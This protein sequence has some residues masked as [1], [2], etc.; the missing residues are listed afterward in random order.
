MGKAAHAALEPEV[1]QHGGTEIVGDGSYV[2]DGRGDAGGRGLEQAAGDRFGD[3]V[4][5]GLDLQAYAGQ[6]G[7]DT[8]VQVGGKA[9]GLSSSSRAVT[10]AAR[11]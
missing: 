5:G 2:V 7:A 10:I 11:L 9:D 3:Q 4:T 1:V 8:V 6:R